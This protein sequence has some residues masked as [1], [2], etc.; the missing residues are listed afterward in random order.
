MRTRNSDSPKSAAPAKRTPQAGKRSAANAKTQTP[1]SSVDPPT[2]SP[3]TET[4]TPKTLVTKR[5]NAAR[6]KQVKPGDAT[7]KSEPEQSGL[8]RFM[9]IF[10][11]L[12][13]SSF[14]AV[15]VV[16]MFSL[17]DDDDDD[18]ILILVSHY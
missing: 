15:L 6:A 7:S 13:T 4:A 17:D 10:I 2:E 14:C 1:T 3:A 18:N 11:S 16:A 5:A 12:S 8:L 9:S